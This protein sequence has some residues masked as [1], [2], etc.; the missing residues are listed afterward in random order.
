MSFFKSKDKKIP[1]DSG[2]ADD[3]SWSTSNL[4]PMNYNSSSALVSSPSFFSGYDSLNDDI[5]KLISV[6]TTT[7]SVH[8]LLQQVMPTV[9]MESKGGKFYPKTIVPNIAA[10][11]TRVNLIQTNL[12]AD[13]SPEVITVTKVVASASASSNLTVAHDRAPVATKQNILQIPFDT[14]EVVVPVVAAKLKALQSSRQRILQLNALKKSNSNN[15]AIQC[16]DEVFYNGLANDDVRHDFLQCLSMCLDY[17]DYDN[18]LG[19]VALQSDDYSRFLP[20]FIQVLHIYTKLDFSTG[21]SVAHNWDVKKCPN[22]PRDAVLDIGKFGFATLPVRVDITRNLVKHTLPAGMTK[23]QRLALE[24]VFIGVCDRINEIAPEFQGQYFSL[25]PGHA[26]QIDRVT[27]QAYQASGILFGDMTADKYMTSAGFAGD[28]P[29]GR[30]CFVSNDKSLV[31]WFGYEEHIRIRF[32]RS[33]TILNDTWDMA[34]RALVLFDQLLYNEGGFARH[35]RFGFVASSPANMGTGVRASVV[36]SLPYLTASGKLQAVVQS[37]GLQAQGREVSA[38]PKL[39]QTEAE[40]LVTLYKGIEKLQREE[41][42]C[43][44]SAS[45]VPNGSGISN[46]IKDLL[47]S[48]V[49]TN[50]ASNPGPWPKDLAVGFDSSKMKLLFLQGAPCTDKDQIGDSFATNFAFCHISVG[51]ILQAESYRAGS[52]HAAVIKEKMSLGQA[53]PNSIVVPLLHEALQSITRGVMA[54]GLVVSGFPLDLEQSFMFLERTGW[55]PDSL[56]FID[57]PEGVLKTKLQSRYKDGSASSRLLDIATNI[58]PVVRHFEAKK[59]VLKL[60]FNASKIDVFNTL[61]DFVSS[62][63]VVKDLPT[64]SA[65]PR[66]ASTSSLKAPEPGTEI[67]SQF[68]VKKNGFKYRLPTEPK[69]NLIQA[70]VSFEYSLKPIPKATMVDTTN[71][72]STVAMSSPVASSTVSIMAAALE[73]E[74]SRDGNITRGVKGRATVVEKKTSISPFAEKFLQNVAAPTTAAPPTKR[75][76]VDASTSSKPP[77]QPV[78]VAPAAIASPKP[79][80]APPIVE[81]RPAQP[82]PIPTPVLAAPAVEQRA[83]A[84]VPS[85]PTGPSPEAITAQKNAEEAARPQNAVGSPDAAPIERKPSVNAEGL[86]AALKKAEEARAAQKQAEQEKSAEL[87]AQKQAAETQAAAKKLAQDEKDV[88]MAAQRKAEEAEKQAAHDKAVAEEN[89]IRAEAARMEALIKAMED[90]EET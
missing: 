18:K 27:Q 8:P 80:L 36:M 41:D 62:G 53:V 21:R 25:T 84:P 49:P 61:K 7:P 66:S 12:P 88:V 14:N 83:A 52:P 74:P 13:S 67:V 90:D 26:R 3:V 75:T 89:R 51:N 64:F 20:F 85:R 32:E 2:R 31:V 19:C 50:Y 37:L 4:Y 47:D 30:G 46:R 40:N 38:V 23:A 9:A 78:V 16:F 59:R 28:W 68:G 86:A 11:A 82:L 1:S 76:S 10:V 72:S 39:W 58:P 17:P 71:S 73:V 79:V 45:V 77:P 70:P 63:C 5:F 35:D 55:T 87:A 29:H 81:S 57:I 15:I 44:P 22:L 60:N 69:S 34:Q 65:L 6:G 33:G 42:K 48:R 56:V 54:T 43:T 24:R